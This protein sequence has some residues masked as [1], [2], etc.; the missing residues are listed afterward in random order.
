M[1][2]KVSLKIQ[3]LFDPNIV[4]DRIS[5]FEADFADFLREHGKEAVK[6]KTYGTAQ[7]EIIIEVRSLD[8]LDKMRNQPVKKSKLAKE[9]LKG[10]VK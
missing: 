5:D 7:G 9:T 4:W 10:V 6:L 2:T 8:R 1:E 3:L